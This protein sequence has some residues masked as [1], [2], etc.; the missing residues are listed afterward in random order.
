MDL[1]FRE[2]TGTIIISHIG[3]NLSY[4]PGKIIDDE[5]IQ[6]FSNELVMHQHGSKSYKTKLLFLLSDDALNQQH[7]LR[8][9]LSH[10]ILREPRGY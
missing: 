9:E 7:N 8:N 1:I 6:S 3:A 4:I 2:F 5:V 10:L